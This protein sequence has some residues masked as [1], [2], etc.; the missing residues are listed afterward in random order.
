MAIGVE[1]GFQ[2]DQKKYKI[3]KQ[4]ALML[5]P[6]FV[7]IPLPCEQLPF[8]VL[9]AI[10]QVNKHDSASTQKAVESWEEERQVS[11][12]AENLIQ[13]PCWRKV[14]PN[15]AD[16]VCDFTGVKDNLWLNLSTGRIGS[17]RQLWDGSGGNGAA[18]QHFEETGRKYPLVVKLGTIT[19][20][21]AD[22]F[23][24]AK[25]EDDMVLDPKL[26][27]HLAHWGINMMQ[28]EKTEKTIAELEIQ[29]NIQFDFMKITEQGADLQPL[30]GPGYTGLRNLGNSCY[31]NSVLQVLWSLPELKEKYLA[32]TNQIFSQA[33]KDAMNDFPSQMAKVGV[34]L[35]EGKTGFTL[36][37]L[38]LTQTYN[39]NGNGIDIP[40]T[41]IT[42]VSPLMFKLLVGRNHREFS[43]S[44]QQDCVEYFMH[45]LDVM[46]SQE[47]E[48][49]SR[50]TGSKLSESLFRFQ[51]EER[52]ECV[53]S[54]GVSY[55][56]SSD[57][58]FGLDVP[59]EFVTVHQES[60]TSVPVGDSE[61]VLSE[62]KE[63]TVRSVPFEAC[64]GRLFGETQIEDVYSPL[65]GGKGPAV[66]R[67]RMGTFPPYLIIYIKRY[68][69]DQNDWSFKKMEV[70][71]EMPENL[72][73]EMFRAKGAQSDE[74][75]Q[76]EDEPQQQQVSNST[77]ANI[78]LPQVDE[79]VV[80]HLMDIGFPENGCRRAVITTG[81]CGVEAAMNWI[82]EHQDDPN[83]NTPIEA[84]QSQ[85]PV[86][87]EVDGRQAEIDMITGMG[88][89][90]RQAE[91]ALKATGYDVERA[92]DWLL[93]RMDNLEEEVQKVLGAEPTQQQSQQQ[94]SA[95]AH[96]ELPQNN[97][98]DK[99]KFLD[100]S[101]QYQLLGFVSH[102]GANTACGHYVAHVKKGDRWVIF[103][104]EKVAVSFKVPKDVGYMYVYQRQA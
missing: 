79:S 5:M 20:H 8:V 91:A 69:Q 72:D 38:T 36:P 35:V 57:R 58:L 44:H 95:Q 31:M 71:L 18:L 50:L 82:L 62:E 27:E 6:D 66:Q 65:L 64:L 42:S 17:G 93:S 45:L 49:T 25:D 81:N 92:G 29:K 32:D 97:D 94:S 60:I 56:Y 16:W 1:G 63:V 52:T 78:N 103:N 33:P 51:K 54:K 96:E 4:Q 67:M 98:K 104:D 101:A 70:Q 47:K 89:T 87:M 59:K 77:Q 99:S 76:P 55:N 100:G 15:P 28:M 84:S 24:Y 40:D 34:A 80:Q 37:P 26:A 9:Q 21:G 10:E 83:F 39:Q 102:I 86:P 41:D 7:K 48:H 75:L 85:T 13:E 23:S 68:Y 30:W 19:P 88:F 90:K 74:L 61:L 14:S 12:Y 22:V 43:T 11:K 53:K 73:L 46:E 2:V 3:E